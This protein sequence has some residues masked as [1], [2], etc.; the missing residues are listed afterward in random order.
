VVNI[1]NQA[2]LPG[3]VANRADTILTTINC[4]AT[5]VAMFLVDRMGRK[6]LLSVGSGGIVIALA[7]AGILFHGTERE[8]VDCKGFFQRRVDKNALDVTFNPESSA[9]AT[10]GT[11]TAGVL[12][13]G[14]PAQLTLVYA[15]GGY[16]NVQTRRTDD[17]KKLPI[18]VTREET[19]PKSRIEGWLSNPFASYKE[20]LTAPL[21]I[22]RAMI[23]PAPSALHGWL[24]AAC[25]FTFITLFAIGPGVCVWLAMTELM[26]TRIRSN[27]M[28]FAMFFNTII[29]SS[30]AWVFMP[31]VGNHGYSMMFFFWAGCTVIYFITTAFFLPETKG[32][33]LEEIEE[34]FSGCAVH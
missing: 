8:C 29:S 1:L 33:T 7:L 16:E 4:L 6:F 23:G 15:Y 2:G 12:D 25:L 34:H 21:T 9:Q 3:S 17:Q 32:K 26:P 30:I 27:G 18:A 20:G 5:V 22:K 24:V 28:G 31:T 10:A 13:H 19:V 14:R 11:S